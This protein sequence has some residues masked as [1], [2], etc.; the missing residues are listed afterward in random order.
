[1]D[2]NTWWQGFVVVISLPLVVWAFYITTVFLK[3][4]ESRSGFQIFDPLL[5]IQDPIDL[6][7]PIFLTTYV[8]I[9]LGVFGSFNNLRNS[10][11]GLHSIFYLL[12]FRII[13]MSLVPFEP[14]MNIIPLQDDFLSNTFYSG[15]VLLKDLFFSGHTASIA[16][17][18][19]L[20]QNKIIRY[21]L[22]VASFGV[23]TMLIAQHV[24][25]SIDVV[26]AYMF[27]Y[28]AY[29]VGIFSADRLVIF[30]RYYSLKIFHRI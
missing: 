3:Y 17:L 27:A 25:Y 10:I 13:A 12:I 30:S 7:R 26:C 8:S 6:S 18:A 1:M 28:I 20:T 2:T 23:G 24:H 5:M 9:C 11:V 15:Q 14:P 19:F 4:N 16:V 29:Q 21:I 22:F